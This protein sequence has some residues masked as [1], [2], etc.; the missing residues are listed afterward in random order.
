MTT[1]PFNPLSAPSTEPESIVLNTFVTWNRVLAYDPTLFS[2]KYIFRAT[3]HSEHTLVGSYI[4]NGAWGFTILAAT[5][6]AWNQA[7]QHTWDMVVVRLSDSA[8]TIVQSGVID[9]FLTTSDRRDHAEIMLA[10]I[11]SILEGRADSDVESY[12]IKDRSITKMSIKELT[13]WRNHYLA[14]IGQRPDNRGGRKNTL[15]VRFV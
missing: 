8:E 1:D 3:G 5:S 13:E 9:F 7:G 15:K 12:T 14:E 4:S 10:K 2:V 6:H 11:N